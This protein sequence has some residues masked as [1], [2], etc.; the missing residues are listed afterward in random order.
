MF[1]SRI[2]KAGSDL[3]MCVANLLD[4]Y[5]HLTTKQDMEALIKALRE[6]MEHEV[7]K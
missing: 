1:A 6:I 5:S 4:C 7:K 2:A 3:V